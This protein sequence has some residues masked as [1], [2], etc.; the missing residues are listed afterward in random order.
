M[1]DVLARD[2][3]GQVEEAYHEVILEL[4]PAGDGGGPAALARTASTAMPPP[5]FPPST[6]RRKRAKSR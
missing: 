2:A 3:P 1:N 4:G 6:H 5:T